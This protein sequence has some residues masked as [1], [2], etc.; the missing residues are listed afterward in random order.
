MRGPL[1]L[2]TLI[3]PLSNNALDPKDLDEDDLYA[4]FSKIRNYESFSAERYSII[5]FLVAEGFFTNVTLRLLIREGDIILKYFLFC[6][7]RL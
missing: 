2:G 1:S 3:G 5:E 6:F 7:I 4:N